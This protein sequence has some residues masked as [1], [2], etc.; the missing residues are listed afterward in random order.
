MRREVMP[1]VWQRVPNARLRVVAGPRHEFFWNALAK[2]GERID[3][4]PRIE[5]QGFVEDLRPLYAQ[6]DVVVV[7][8]EV[9]AGTTAAAREAS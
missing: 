2:P 9:S 7:P 8:L 5:I 3:S 4:D 1:R 6:A